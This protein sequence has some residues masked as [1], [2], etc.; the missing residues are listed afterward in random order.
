VAAKANADM[1]T[2]VFRDLIG[3][4]S[5]FII[6]PFSFFLS[7]HWAV[8]PPGMDTQKRCD[9]LESSVTDRNFLFH[10]VT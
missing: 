5:D 7:F 6:L 8:N 4:M 2:P 10:G 3:W 9:S 1:A